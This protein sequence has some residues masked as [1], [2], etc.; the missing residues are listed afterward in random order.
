MQGLHEC[1]PE[2]E[3]PV[4]LEDCEPGELVVVLGFD[5]TYRANRLQ[6]GHKA[7]QN[8]GCFVVPPDVAVARARNGYVDV[9][10][11]VQNT[12]NIGRDGRTYLSISSSSEKPCSWMKTA[13]RTS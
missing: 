3:L 1:P 7:E 8:V 5:T 2:A 9:R 11:R 13:M 10:C 6:R 4:F 12:Q